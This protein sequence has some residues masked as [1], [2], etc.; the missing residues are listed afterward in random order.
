MT[1]FPFP[2]WVS[3][4]LLACMIC[5]VTYK[6]IIPAFTEINSDF[7]NY[8]TAGS[9]V[10]RGDSIARLYDDQWFQQKMMENGFS[11]QGK[12]APFP[13]AT[14]LVGIPLS[15]ASPIVSMRLLT[16]L[17]CVL[18]VL[19]IIL[20]AQS[21]SISSMESGLLV[22]TSGLGL[23]NCFRLGQLYI[24]LSFLMILGYWLYKRDHQLLAGMAI[25]L[26]VPIKYFP[27][28]LILFF[29]VLRKWRVVQGALVAILCVSGLGV[30][31]LGWSLHQTFFTEVLPPH[32]SGNLTQ[33]DPF[34]SVFQSFQSLFRRLFLFDPVLNPRPFLDSPVLF[35]AFRIILPAG[36]ILF[37]VILG[38]QV[39]KV[40]DIP[41]SNTLFG[42]S[43][44]LV[45]VISPATATYHTLLLWLPTALLLSS[46][47]LRD[48]RTMTAVLLLYCCL[49][50]IPY[51]LFRHFDDGGVLTLFA[52]PR[53]G[54]LT[55]MFFIGCSGIMKRL[56]ETPGTRST[57]S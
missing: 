39:L 47:A 25:G 36:L 21:V 3:G 14:A 27:V 8:Y 33:Q 42:L 52:Y 17:N 6:G 55:A 54:I 28:L 48:K 46:D 57:F 38:R 49:G 37:L 10:V 44:I 50:W 45:L 53:L 23:I 9:I 11:Q 22:F 2:K 15:L 18:V 20:L 12:F 40:D 24:I 35:A 4:S 32:L 26:F 30:G 5:V 19:S 7:P 13:P 31:I 51:N 43:S 34:S 16:I 1:I 29:T 56:D 41:M